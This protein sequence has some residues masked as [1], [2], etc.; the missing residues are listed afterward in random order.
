MGEIRIDLV[1]DPDDREHL[2]MLCSEY[3]ALAAKAK[4]IEDAQD[5]LKTLIVSALDNVR[6]TLPKMDV[7]KVYGSNWVVSW[8]KG[9]RQ[10][11]K[12]KLIENAV[13]ADVIE[14]S[15]ARGAGYWQVD[16]KKRE[17]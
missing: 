2:E 10:L 7:R 4:R 12:K 1:P 6:S 9:R 11:S 14:A 8:R 3:R 5:D 17:E 13:P 15:Y 16:G